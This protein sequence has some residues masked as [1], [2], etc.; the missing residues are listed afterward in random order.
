MKAIPMKMQSKATKI[1]LE[2]INFLTDASGKRTA[3]LIDLD[4]YGSLLEEFFDVVVSQQRLEE[5]DRISLDA[6]K[7]ELIE[8]ERL[9]EDV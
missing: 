1:P 9:S 2:G 7:K 8:E 4:K 6:F 3:V 5:D